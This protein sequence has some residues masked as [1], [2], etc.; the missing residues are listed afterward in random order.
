MIIPIGFNDSFTASCLTSAGQSILHPVTHCPHYAQ[1]R[2]T[3]QNAL[4]KIIPNKAN[5]NNTMSSATAPNSVSSSYHSSQQQ[6]FTLTLPLV[7]ENVRRILAKK[8]SSSVYKSFQS[9][10]GAFILALL[11]IQKKRNVWMPKPMNLLIP[12]FQ[13]CFLIEWVLA[14]SMEMIANKLYSLG[15]LEKRILLRSPTEESRYMIAR[16][17]LHDRLAN[18][19]GEK[20]KS[21]DFHVFWV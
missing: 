20:V 1:P 13:L 3:C 6:Q 21:K 19:L 10:N 18:G 16:Q 17:H 5:T 4:E 11:A 2:A 9:G 7:L 8:H 12:N 15:R 14:S